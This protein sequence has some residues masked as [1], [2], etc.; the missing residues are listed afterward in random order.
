MP[1][2]EVDQFCLI[3][4]DARRRAEFQLVVEQPPRQPGFQDGRIAFCAIGADVRKV[5][6][7]DP[8]VGRAR[9]ICPRYLQRPAM[10]PIGKAIVKPGARDNREPVVNCV[11]RIDADL[12]PPQLRA[13]LL[14]GAVMRV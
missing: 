12:P 9:A 13:G 4:R 11:A 14:S 7:A 6:H 8:R 10:R 2:G 3:E 5:R 1:R